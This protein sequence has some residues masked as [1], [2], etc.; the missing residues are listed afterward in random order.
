[1]AIETHTKK[2]GLLTKCG[3]HVSALWEAPADDEFVEVEGEDG[4]ISAYQFARTGGWYVPRAKKVEAAVPAPLKLACRGPSGQGQ[5]VPHLVQVP[6]A[7]GG[8]PTPKPPET[9]TKAVRASTSSR[10]D[11]L[12]NNW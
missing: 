4:T 12:G 11:D 2:K 10:A 5:Q 3:G 1:M 7:A 8:V 9:R 6:T